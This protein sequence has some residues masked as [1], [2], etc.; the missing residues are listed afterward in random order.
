MLGKEKLTC[1]KRKGPDGQ[2]LSSSCMGLTLLRQEAARHGMVATEIH[3]CSDGNRLIRRHADCVRYVSEFRGE[4]EAQIQFKASGVRRCQRY[5]CGTSFAGV[6]RCG[7][8]C[9]APRDDI[10]G[11]IPTGTVQ[12]IYCDSGSDWSTVKDI[13]IL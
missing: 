12:E 5:C 10:S 7:S 9:I 6:V 4:S 11:D 13:H 8:R 1:V 3:V 2:G